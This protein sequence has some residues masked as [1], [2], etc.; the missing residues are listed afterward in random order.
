[1]KK[2]FLLLLMA[3]MS[4][5]G[6][7]VNLDATKFKAPNIPYGS[8]ALPG[9][10]VEDREYAETATYTIDYDHFYTSATGTGEIAVRSGETNN[11]MTTAPGEYF[12]KVSGTGTYMGSYVYVSFLI[13]PSIITIDFTDG[14]SKTYGEDDPEGGFTYSLALNGEAVATDAA[15]AALVEAS[16]LWVSREKVGTTEGEKAGT[17]AY[18]F[19]T[20]DEYYQI[21]RLGTDAENKFTIN[22]K[23]IAGTFAISLAEGTWTY[24]GAN[25]NPDITVKDGENVIDANQF[26]FAYSYSKDNVEDYYA[27]DAHANAGFYKVTASTPEGSNYSL[28]GAEAADLVAGPF[29]IGQAPLNIYVNS[30]E[31]EYDGN[32]DD[33]STAT[34]AYSG[35]QGADAESANPF[36]NG[37]AAF[38]AEYKTA[39]DA[40]KNFGPHT[41]KAKNVAAKTNAKLANYNY[42]LLETGKL[43]VTAK[44]IT[45]KPTDDEKAFGTDDPEFALTVT[46]AVADD[47][48]TIQGAYDITRDAG[49]ELGTYTMT[50]TQ[51]AELADAT[52]TLLKNYTITPETGTFTINGGTLYVYPKSE[53]IIYGKPTPTFTVVATTA[54]GTEVELTTAPTVKFKDAAYAEAAPTNAGTYVLIVDGDIVAENYANIV[55]LDGQYTINQKP[56]TPVIET[57][58]LQEGDA[59]DQTKVTFTGLV[60]G[61]E[62][63]YQLVFN[64]LGDDVI[65]YDDEAKVWV[66]K[67]R[68]ANATYATGIKIARPDEIGEGYANANYDIDWTATAKLVIGEGSEVVGG[69]EINGKAGIEEYQGET[70]NVEI[71]LGVRTRSI[72]AT[73]AHTWAKETW[74]TMVLPFDVT[75]AELSEQLGYAIVNRVDADKTSEGN[76][77]FKLEMQSIPANEPF[78]VK[79]AGAIADNTKLKFRNKL[80]V[81]G[82][83]SVA[84][85]QG[86]K[87][88]GAYEELTIDKTK[89]LFYFLRGDNAKWAH[90]GASSENTWKVVPFDAYVDQSGSASARELTFTFQE[91]DGSYTA[92][93]SIEA[94]TNDIESAKTGLY[95]IGGMKLQGAPTQKGVYIKD[96]KKIVI[97]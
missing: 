12:I 57:Q 5:T 82:D 17:Y 48:A 22:P 70:Q 54:G 61:D 94:N 56:L 21:A 75:V 32:V 14:Q 66:I 18:T 34:I 7:A 85:G 31:K 4:L 13:Y 93:R 55:K 63:D 41:L 25:Q 39:G 76:V 60:E 87:F 36:D 59:L 19:G 3:F 96:G 20:E 1:M 46:G 91:L 8:N 74:N 90:I 9:V 80:I 67:E 10:V 84:A 77:V 71:N 24:N 86:Y 44:A 81:A 83:P 47:V 37:G 30:F 26:A 43:T 2:H 28:A 49:E 53:S 69:V 64:G 27:V 62:I 52:K 38:V 78:C 45:V 72:P 92:I 29:Q 11:L 95:T 42:N 23:N 40:N 16:G 50:A 79:T 68:A 33:L 15:K 97:K 88:V 65:E 89:S 35:L 6:Y 73:T 58:T 51:K